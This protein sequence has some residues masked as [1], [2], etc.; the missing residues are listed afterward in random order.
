MVNYCSYCND[1]PYKDE[2]VSKEGSTIGGFINGH[3]F[4]GWCYRLGKEEEADSEK[5]RMRRLT[6][7]A[8][9]KKTV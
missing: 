8:E 6:E 1:G 9:A 4:C 3:W 5:D 7:V 2:S